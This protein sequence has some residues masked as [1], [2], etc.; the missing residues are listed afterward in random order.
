MFVYKQ[1]T[2]KLLEF[3]QNATAKTK[4][5]DEVDASATLSVEERIEN[6]L[7]KVCP[8]DSWFLIDGYNKTSSSRASTSTSSNTQRKHAWIRKS[9][10]AH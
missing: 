1:A 9:I 3:A 2:E 8:N 5:T 10:P 7:V 6:A 4:V